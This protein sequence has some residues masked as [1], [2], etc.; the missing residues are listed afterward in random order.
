MAPPPPA[1]SAT[2]EIRRNILTNPSAISPQLSAPLSPSNSAGRLDIDVSLPAADSAPLPPFSWRGVADR[3]YDTETEERRMRRGSR[4]RL[5]ARPYSTNRDI[6]IGPYDAPTNADW[7][8]SRV[9]AA[10]GSNRIML[11]RRRVSPHASFTLG[12]RNS[13]L[14]ECS[15]NSTPLGRRRVTGRHPAYAKP[16]NVPRYLLHSHNSTRFFTMELEKDIESIDNISERV[17]K[18]NNNIQ[19]AERILL[20]TCWDAKSVLLDLGSDGVNVR[21]GGTAKYGDR[22]AAAVLTN[23][24]IDPSVGIYYFEVVRLALQS[25]SSSINY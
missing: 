7:D 17:D 8:G 11:A 2:D 14:A 21:F 4:D 24:P 25:K 19:E 22:D 12:V 3:S 6:N 18:R 20:P 15:S 9:D 13:M 1:I 16:F 23:Q 5:P 10:S